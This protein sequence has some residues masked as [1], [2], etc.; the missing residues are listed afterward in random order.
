MTG[1]LCLC[2]ICCDWLVMHVLYLTCLVDWDRRYLFGSVGCACAAVGI[3]WI[4]AVAVL[5]L[6]FTF[7]VNYCVP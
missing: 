4:C 2:S 7:C 6:P 3:R 5:L 1:W